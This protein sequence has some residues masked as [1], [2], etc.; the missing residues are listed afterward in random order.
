MVKHRA[1]TTWYEEDGDPMMAAEDKVVSKDVFFGRW[2]PNLTDTEGWN[3]KEMENKVRNKPK[4][5]T[6]Y[7]VK[8][9]DTMPSEDDAAPFVPNYICFVTEGPKDDSDITP[10]AP[11]LS[12]KA[13]DKSDDMDPEA[14]VADDIV[15]MVGTHEW[16]RLDGCDKLYVLCEKNEDTS[17]MPPRGFGPNSGFGGFGATSAPAATPAEPKAEGSNKRPLE[18]N[19]AAEGAKRRK[20]AESAAPAAAAAAAPIQ[21]G[22]PSASAPAQFGV[23]SASA[24]AQFGVPPAS[25]AAAPATP[26]QFGVP[27]ASSA[28]AAAAPIQFGVPSASA[29]PVQFGVSSS[30][31]APA[32]TFGVTSSST[33][34]TFGVPST[35][36]S[37]FGVP[38]AAG[39]S[40]APAFGGGFDFS[41][42]STGYSGEAVFP[43]LWQENTVDDHR[44][45]I[46]SGM[47][48]IHSFTD[49]ES[50]LKLK[51]KIEN[52]LD[53]H[54]KT[55]P[56]QRVEIQKWVERN[57]LARSEEYKKLQEEY[58]G[59]NVA[60]KGPEHHDEMQKE[61]TEKK[62]ELLKSDEIKA[63]VK[64]IMQK[65]YTEIAKQVK[66]I[67][68]R[69]VDKLV[70]TR[71]ALTAINK[72]RKAG[73][74][75]DRSDFKILRIFPETDSKG[76]TCAFRPSKKINKSVGQADECYPAAFVQLN[77]FTGLPM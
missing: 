8:S 68:K 48:I 39:S 29:A 55:G 49:P 36:A 13:A 22:V 16:R 7:V 40:S 62:A 10:Q 32:P 28:P 70:E 19:D 9:V 71:E 41:S 31:S 4:N 53:F 27:S 25:S 66:Q 77:P 42:M 44:R 3:W 76:K 57:V 74:M 51:I 23:P 46:S 63:Q 72:D 43:V 45:E 37:T 34:A 69:R 12:M 50:G 17:K 38:S 1:R 65:H 75:Y 5:E 73:K 60:Y 35:G 58:Q 61:F 15:D 59:D 56:K 26:I 24:L 11:R 54:K 2:S 33:A 14:F 21:F 67:L 30:S 20:E 18:S 6:W 52:D 64:A 47:K